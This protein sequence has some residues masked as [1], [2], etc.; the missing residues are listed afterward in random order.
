LADKVEKTFTGAAEA[1]RPEEDDMDVNA[2]INQLTAVVLE[3]DG[4]HREERDSQ[5]PRRRG[6]RRRTTWM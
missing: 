5:E 4:H 6:D 3:L 2:G 1:R